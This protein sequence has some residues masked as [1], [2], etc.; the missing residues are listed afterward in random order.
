MDQA[1][2]ELLVSPLSKTALVYQ[3]EKN[4]LWSVVDKLAFPIEGGIPIM[5]VESARALS[6]EEIDRLKEGIMHA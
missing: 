1:L 5:L 3:K 2:I 4:E 6:L